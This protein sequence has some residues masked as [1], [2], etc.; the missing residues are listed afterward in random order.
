M[1]PNDKIKELAKISGS[2]PK[3]QAKAMGI[4]TQSFYNRRNEKITNEN[5]TEKNYEDFLF[6]VTKDLLIKKRQIR[7]ARKRFDEI[8]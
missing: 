8:R 2:P 5:F 7:N 6:F 1:T 3:V 4:S